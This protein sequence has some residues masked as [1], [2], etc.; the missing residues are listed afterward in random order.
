MSMRMIHTKPWKN[1][2]AMQAILELSWKISRGMSGNFALFSLNMKKILIKEPNSI[3]QMT[4]GELQLFIV[5]SFTKNTRNCTYGNIAPPNSRPRSNINI[6]PKIDRL[7]NQST[8]LIPSRILVL[9][10]CTS[11]NPRISRKADP[12]TGKFIQKHHL[13]QCSAMKTA[14]TV[15][16][17]PP[18]YSL[19]ECTTQYWASASCDSPH[20]SWKPHNQTPLPTAGQSRP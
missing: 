8:A 19:R 14:S 11:R 12:E 13:D 9:G 16:D 7:P 20:R 1:P 15:I 2:R 6:S 5:S 3:K 10:L 17:L 4:W 18:S